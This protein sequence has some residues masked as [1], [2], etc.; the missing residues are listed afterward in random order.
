MMSL[1]PKKYG[2]WCCSNMF[3]LK[4]IKAPKI[5][6][7]WELLIPKQL[8]SN[9][10]AMHIKSQFFIRVHVPQASPE[11]AVTTVCNVINLENASLW[12]P[13]PHTNMSCGYLQQTLQ[14]TNLTPTWHQ[15]S[16]KAEVFAS[17][18]HTFLKAMLANCSAHLEK[19][20]LGAQNG[21]KQFIMSTVYIV[22]CVEMTMITY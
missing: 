22:P 10:R 20:K 6:T 12:S 5:V 19:W 17:K 21:L 9:C 4:I 7:F 8:F 11:L 15:R 13:S 3:K 18:K 16:I 14:K 2:W 1:D